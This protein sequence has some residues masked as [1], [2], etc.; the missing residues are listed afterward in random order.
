MPSS[1]VPSD[2][3]VADPAS[4]KHLFERTSIG[5]R[6][7]LSTSDDTGTDG[8][9]RVLVVDDEP[10][11]ARAFAKILTQAGYQTSVCHDSRD[12]LALLQNE[13][14]EAVVSDITMPNLNGI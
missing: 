12:A 8:I 5:P 2:L 7:A 4:A 9:G 10:V 3:L 1:R 14:F 13:N 6:P 11:L